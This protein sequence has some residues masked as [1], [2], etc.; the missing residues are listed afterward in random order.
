MR[1]PLLC[2]A[3][4]A[5]RGECDQQQPSRRRAEGLSGH[6]VKY[7]GADSTLLFIIVRVRYSFPGTGSGGGWST[8]SC[9]RRRRR[10]VRLRGDLRN[11]EHQF[12]LPAIAR[13][14]TRA[15]VEEL[16]VAK[17]SWARSLS[18]SGVPLMAVTRSPGAQADA[19]K[20]LAVGAR[21]DPKAPHLAAGEH[22]LRPHD[23]ADDAGSSFT[24]LRMRS[25]M[26]SLPRR[27]SAGGGGG[28][29][30]RFP[31]VRRGSNTDSSAPLRSMTAR[32][33]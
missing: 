14:V 5:G 28:A 19:R 15:S 20:G 29:R 1:W 2:G 27:P 21:I 22:R 17:I 16:S 8:G 7:P 13:D 25:S 4:D 33:L 11:V 31:P 32:S 26:A 30:S 24:S 6:C 9:H 10:A 3:D 23:L 18:S 12:L